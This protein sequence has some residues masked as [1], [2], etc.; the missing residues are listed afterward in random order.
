[1][2]NVAYHASP[3]VVMDIRRLRGELHS[4]RPG[5]PPVFEDKE[6]FLLKIHSAEIG[7]SQASLS[8]LLDK[9]VF[10]YPGSPLGNL[11]CSVEPGRIRLKGVLR[12]ALHLRFSIDGTLS[13]TPD[14]ELSVHP[15]SVRAAGIG[16]GGVMR[17]LRLRLDKLLKL[18]P[19]RGIRAVG[20]DLYLDTGRMLPP[21]E[22]RGR[23]TQAR[24]EPGQIVLV[25][26][27]PG[28]R[29][30][31]KLSPPD[32]SSPNF[33]Y[34]QGGSLSFGKL[35]MKET[36]LQIVDADPRDPFDFF[37]D[38]YKEQLVAGYDQNL[39]DGGLIVHMPDYD[40]LGKHPEGDG[41]DARLPPPDRNADAVRSL[42]AR[43]GP[44]EQ[45]L[46]RRPL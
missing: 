27:S 44:G 20:N 32:P 28:E 2:R 43:P 34:Y 1:M 5:R 35:T 36:E 17:V 12:T 21:P 33:M 10:A 3:W 39:P 18:D 25:F 45:Q 37:L 6:S 42:R 46:P 19:E 40:K 4:K 30:A 31:P 22:I 38:H 16:V 24:L 23:V 26:D 14:G 29:P 8:G 7:M 15:T 11:E 13:V 41:R 9:H